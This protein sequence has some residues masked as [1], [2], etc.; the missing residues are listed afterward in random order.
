M[1]PKSSEA[2]FQLQRWHFHHS[3]KC[4]HVT[5]YLGLASFRPPICRLFHLQA[6]LDSSLQCWFTPLNARPFLTYTYAEMLR[7]TLST[8]IQVSYLDKTMTWKYGHNPKNSLMFI[9]KDKQLA[10]C[11]TS[12]LILQRS[13]KGWSQGNKTPK[14]FLLV[15]SRYKRCVQ[16]CLSGLYDNPSQTELEALVFG[17]QK[18]S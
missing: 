18:P 13:Y 9:I 4:V 8:Q 10:N 7:V 1:R 11:D 15:P 6:A 2:S 5:H 16:Y 3:P 14:L 12:T 17:S